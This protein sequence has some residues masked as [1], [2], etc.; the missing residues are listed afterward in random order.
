MANLHE[1]R[2]CPT[3][4]DG[5]DALFAH[6]VTQGACQDRQRN[7]YHK[8]YTCAFNN[9]RVALYGP[10][11][12]APAASEPVPEATEPVPRAEAAARD[13]EPIAP[14]FVEIA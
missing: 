2:N 1:L 10:P 14:G 8:C 9:A 5:A 3:R 4:I 13:P 11:G 12:A 6:K 7:R